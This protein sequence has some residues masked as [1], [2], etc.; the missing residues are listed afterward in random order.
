[1]TENETGLEPKLG[2]PVKS[3][4]TNTVYGNGRFQHLLYINIDKNGLIFV[5]NFV[6]KNN[7]CIVLKLTCFLFKKYL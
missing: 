7:I 5:S 6:S 3:T 1:V 2:V 4:N